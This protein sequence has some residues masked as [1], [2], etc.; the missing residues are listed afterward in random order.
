DLLH[1]NIIDFSQCSCFVL[2]EADRLLSQDFQIM[3]DEMISYLP[4]ERQVM[5]F[6]ATF[7][8]VVEQFIRK[9]MKNPYEI[10]LMNELTLKGNG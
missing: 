8:V 3:L 10:N 5:L 4:R 9:H 6:S 1:K 7:P 2:D